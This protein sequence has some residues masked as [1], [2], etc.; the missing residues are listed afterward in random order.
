MSQIR[1]DIFTD[2][3]VIVE[4]G[5]GPT[6]FHFKKFARD[7]GFCP[8]CERNEAATPPEV[9]AIR[10]PGSSPNGP[11]WSVRVV[12]NSRPQLRIEGQLKRRAEA[13][14]DL[15]NGVG[16]HEII[17]ETSRHDRSL[18]ELEIE[19]ISNVIRAYRARILDLEGDQRVRYVLIF[20]NHG[21]GAG[22]HT[23]S[24]SISQLVA[25]PITPRAVKT[26]LKIARDYFALKERCV[27]C[28]VLQQ[29]LK[30]RKRLITENEDFVAFAPFASRFPFEMTVLPKFHSSAFSRIGATQIDNVSRILRDLLQKLDQSLGGPPY[31]LSLHDRPFLRRRGD[32]W[33]TIEEDFHW[34]IEILPQMF[35][36]TGFEWASG[37]FY[38][39]VPPELAARSLSRGGRV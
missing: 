21:E 24:H 19:E 18:H 1:K 5:E 22:A 27:Y 25:L 12:P 37:F 8:F 2:R 33:N 31:N 20:K 10:N 26:K 4:E 32:Y 3:W 38:N 36:I 35:R 15:M 16:A 7:A 9:F 34:H 39:P 30:G 23:I 13:L 14:H 28:D 11:G 6:E 29:E 17:A